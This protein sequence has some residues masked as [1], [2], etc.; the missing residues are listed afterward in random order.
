MELH[1]PMDDRSAAVLAQ[2][3]VE[4]AARAASIGTAPAGLVDQPDAPPVLYMG[5]TSTDSEDEV[6]LDE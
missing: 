2:T 6:V 5:Q 1:A 4:V 3:L